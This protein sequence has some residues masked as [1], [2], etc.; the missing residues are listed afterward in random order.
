MSVDILLIVVSVLILRQEEVVVEAT[1]F[2]IKEMIGDIIQ[3]FILLLK[4]LKLL[5]KFKEF[6]GVD[7]VF[8][9]TRLILHHARALFSACW[10]NDLGV[11]ARFPLANG[12][13]QE[14]LSGN[15]VDL[16]VGQQVQRDIASLAQL[17]SR[18][19]DLLVEEDVAFLYLLPEEALFIL[20]LKSVSLNISDTHVLDIL[21]P[22]LPEYLPV[23]ALRIVLALAIRRL[24]VQVIDLRHDVLDD[25][26]LLFGSVR[27]RTVCIAI[28]GIVSCH[29]DAG[30]ICDIWVLGLVRE[31]DLLRVVEQIHRFVVD[32]SATKCHLI[33][34]YNLI[35]IPDVLASLSN[36]FRLLLSAGGCSLLVKLTG[37]LLLRSVLLCQLRQ[38]LVAFDLGE[39][40][41]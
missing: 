6:Q 23:V 38:N 35:E 5:V 9:A 17:I 27:I 3:D 13:T 24:P 20:S 28:H 22:P 41:S 36:F 18:I 33:F 25:L 37:I 2:Q 12:D 40:S 31:A 15:L 4:F 11:V 26:T 16:V 21:V 32:G 19:I 8:L 39:A 34:L 14:L 29:F 10:R 1:T 30:L 7:L